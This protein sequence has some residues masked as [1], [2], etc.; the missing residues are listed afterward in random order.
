SSTGVHNGYVVTLRS[1]G[2]GGIA[3]D[4]RRV[5]GMFLG[6]VD[7]WTAEGTVVSWC[8]T[9]TTYAYAAEA[10]SHPAPVSYQQSQHLH[11][12]RRQ[13]GLGRDIPRL[14]IG[15][16]EIQ[17]TCDIDAMTQAVNGHVRRHDTYHDRFDV[18]DN[19]EIH[20]Y[21]IADPDVITLA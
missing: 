3:R 19:D 10:Q 16:W 17:G 1:S 8:P 11:Y 7:D 18:C 14:C 6:T 4:E 5:G 9:A 12:Y 20:R 2:P 13:V 15:A 21:V